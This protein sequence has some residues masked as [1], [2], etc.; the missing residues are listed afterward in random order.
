MSTTKAVVKT[1]V[2]FDASASYDPDKDTLTYRWDFGDGAVGKN[3]TATHQYSTPNTYT[4]KLT[5]NDGKGGIGTATK[6]LQVLAVNAAPS[7]PQI[8]GTLSGH[9]NTAMT[10]SVTSTDADNNNVQYTIAWGDGTTTTTNFTASGT[11]VTETHSWAHVGK[12][13]MTVTATDGI[14]TSVKT[15]SDVLIDVQLVANLGYLIDANGDG[16]Y[17]GFYDYTTQSQ[18]TVQRQSDGTYLIDQNGDQQWDSVYNPVT[19]TVVAYTPPAASKSGTAG[20][21]MNLIL[22]IG[23]VS[24][25]VLLVVFAVAYRRSRRSKK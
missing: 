14:D 17:D 13:T 5:V 11:P 19:K 24:I 12:Y 16:V 15:S 4:V 7:A 21:N 1:T 3:V 23:A 20:D 2:T 6:I 25:V 22:L 18:T 9:Q 8:A 10:F